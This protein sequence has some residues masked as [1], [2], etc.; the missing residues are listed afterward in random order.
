MNQWPGTQV[1]PPVQVKD[2][3][4][5]IVRDLWREAEEDWRGQL[6][7]RNTGIAIAVNPMLDRNGLEPAQ[8]LRRS[9]IAALRQ[10]ESERA[11]PLVVSSVTSANADRA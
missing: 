3:R 8:Q 2:L 4:E 10:A 9:R 5:L 11:V 6:K 1:T 7:D